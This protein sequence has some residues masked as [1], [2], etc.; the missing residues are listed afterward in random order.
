MRRGRFTL[1]GGRIS[2]V[3]WVRQELEGKYECLL[4]RSS[5]STTRKATDSSRP[6][7]AARI[8]SHISRRFK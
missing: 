3:L 8:C 4:V 7:K 5:G 6:M 1:W 2:S